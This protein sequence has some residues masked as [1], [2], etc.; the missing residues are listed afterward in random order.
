MKL[1]KRIKNAFKN[2]W[3][4]LRSGIKETYERLKSE[5]PAFFVKIRNT[6]LVVATACGG[7]TVFYGNLPD[8][9]LG[10][11][12][13]WLIRTMTFTGL[14]AAFIAQCARKD[15]SQQKDSAA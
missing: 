1:F 14:V 6:A 13:T 12:P 3:N 4:W 5:T 9:A 10:F 8:S 2:A 7:A 11:V 15:P